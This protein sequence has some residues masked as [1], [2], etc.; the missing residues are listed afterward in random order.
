MFPLFFTTFLCREAP[1][2]SKYAFPLLVRQEG[3]Q[4]KL[5]G[6]GQKCRNPRLRKA[7]KLL[8]VGF[9]GYHGTSIGEARFY[10]LTKEV[11][12]VRDGKLV[13]AEGAWNEYANVI[14]SMLP[15][16]ALSTREGPCRAAAYN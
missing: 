8:G 16:S 6:T 15:S 14:F 9:K 13:E 11:E 3:P 12:L 2:Q 4:A 7:S 10:N 5:G 1:S